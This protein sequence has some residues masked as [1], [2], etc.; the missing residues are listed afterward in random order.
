M[1]R[2]LMTSCIAIAIAAGTADAQVFTEHFDG[3]SLLPSGW[4]S[5]NTSPAGPGSS[6]DWQQT[7]GSALDWSPKDG[8]GYVTIG[9]NA[10]IGA[11]DIS[12]YLLS[13]EMPMSNGDTISFW[14]RTQDNPTYP[15]R[16]SVVLNTSAGSAP[17]GFTSTLLT[18]NP[19]LT[20]TDYPSTWTQYTVTVSGLPETNSTTNGRF[21]FLY[22]PINGGPSGDNSDRIGVDEVNYTPVPSPGSAALLGLG[23][24]ICG[25]R[26]R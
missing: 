23:G 7:P 9:Y 14:T 12:V 21:A 8:A 17:E 5:V 18:I 13:P 3:S 25:R 20:T 19:N 6:P 15:D 26:R 22:N 24:L 4:A 1:I 2:T 11:N 16:L 10:T